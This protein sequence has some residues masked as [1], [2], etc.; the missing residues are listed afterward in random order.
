MSDGYC[1]VPDNRPKLDLGE[2]TQLWAV[3]TALNCA[4]SPIETCETIAVAALKV[5]ERRHSPWRV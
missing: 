4:T 2:R 1:Q 3:S 5:R